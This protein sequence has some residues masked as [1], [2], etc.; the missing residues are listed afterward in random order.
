MTKYEM[1]IVE[2]RQGSLI[3]DAE[4]LEQ[5]FELTRE[6]YDAGYVFW[7]TTDESFSLDQEIKG[8]N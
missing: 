1:Q 8:A 2:T 5:A 4:T 3:I 7:H 6:D